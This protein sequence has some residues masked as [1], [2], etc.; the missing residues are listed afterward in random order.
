M[1]HHESGALFDDHAIGW[2]DQRVW[3]CFP[4]KLAR[5]AAEGAPPPG[6]TLLDV[7]TGTGVLIPDL[8]AHQPEVVWACDVSSEMLKQVRAKFGDDPR[9]WPIQADAMRLDLA[10]HPRCL[11][12]DAG[13]MSGY[14]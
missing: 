13:K 7:G 10:S 6:G 14:S 1:P 5:V 8:L 9:V 2:D 3:P 4:E 11:H 12:K